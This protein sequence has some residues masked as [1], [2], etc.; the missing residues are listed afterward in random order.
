MES[1]TSENITNEFLAF[2]QSQWTSNGSNIYL[3][4]SVGIGTSLPRANLDVY[5]TVR[6]GSSLNVSGN[7]NVVGNLT[8]SNLIVTGNLVNVTTNLQISNS[9]TINNAGT[10]TALKVVQFESV[11]VH[12]NNVAEFWDYQTLA[13][14][15]NGDG[16]VGIHTTLINPYAFAVAGSSNI[17]Y[18]KTI[19]VYSS[20]AVVASNL[21]GNVVGSNTVSASGLYGPVI[22]SNTVSASGLYGQ[23]IGSNTVSS[24]GLYGPVVGSNTISGTTISGSTLYG[25]LAGSNT[26]VG[27]TIYGPIA[28]ANTISASTIYGQLAGS[29]TIA[30]SSLTLG[31]ALSVANGGTGLTSTS[32]NFVFA[33]PTTGAAAAPTWRALVAADVPVAGS[34]STTYASG[35]ILYGQASG[36]PASTSTFIYSTTGS[37]SI[38]IGTASATSNLYVTGNSYISNSVTTSNVYANAYWSSTPFY[39]RNRLIN[40]DFF[41]DQRNN[42]SA[43]T[44]TVTTNVI[45][46]WKFNMNT[47]ETGRVQCGENLGS[48]P[49]P[50]GFTSYYGMKVT[51][52]AT[53]NAADY[54]NLSQ[55]IEGTNT[56]DFG[57]GTSWA[58]AVTISFWVQASASGTYGCFVRNNGTFS[59]SYTFTYTVNSINTWEYKTVTI[60]GP[61][62]GVWTTSQTVGVE[63]GFVIG[64]GTTY[65][66]APGSWAN[67]N[68]TGPSGTL[69]NMVGTLN[70]T[71]YITGVQFE[72]GS[73]ATSFE[74]R[75]YS[76]ELR[77]CQRYYEILIARLGGYNTTGA[78]LRGSV[79]FRMQKRQIGSPGLSASV[80]ETA[81]NLGTL[82]VDNSNFTGDSVRIFAPV[83]ASG[84]GFAQW[85]VI[86][87]CEF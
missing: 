8:V 33:G 50:T 27:S 31:T 12:T 47:G 30:G 86:V 32:A 43:V 39:F 56:I 5:G 15:I 53:V 25:P 49:S 34:L 24:S 77:L 65:Q 51:T 78:N 14:L 9:V 35:Q 4:T 42:A 61:T 10:S 37:G 29:N 26:I 11:P 48:V 83:T 64:N 44:P 68:F 73:V 66:T 41:I 60:P 76:D 54:Y 80:V 79:Y 2:N 3:N 16:N 20:N 52:T 28:G 59:N 18:I 55:T 70:S 67:G 58:K 7:A 69:V 57:W 82:T 17:D 45:D 46:R 84:D 63:L 74:R 21:Y 1:I 81:T 72:I 23:L 62:A 75:L 6:F 19:N 38:G 40:A 36:V 85:K 71:L 87:D 22:G 13:L